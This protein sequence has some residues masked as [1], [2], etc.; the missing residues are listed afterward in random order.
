MEAKQ[1]TQPST[2]FRS[3][4][5]KWVGVGLCMFIVFHLLPAHIVMYGFSPLRKIQGWPLAIWASG[6]IAIVGFAI[7]YLSRGYTVLEPG[8]AGLAY[9]VVVFLVS[10][11]T[12]GFLPQR[13]SSE[14]GLMLVSLGAVFVLGVGGALIG[15]LFQLK[16]PPSKGEG[17]F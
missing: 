3:F 1:P 16:K 12:G 11:I 13:A 2:I 4:N 10:R 8:L 7:G 15:E 17:G 6:G 14:L 5:W 9:V